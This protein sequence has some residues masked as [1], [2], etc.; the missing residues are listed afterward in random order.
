MSTLIAKDEQIATLVTTAAFLPLME[1]DR[2]ICS[3]NLLVEPT[4]ET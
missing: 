2:G 1:P 3:W 4:H